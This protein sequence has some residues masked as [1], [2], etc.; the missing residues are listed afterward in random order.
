MSESE[1]EVTFDQLIKSIEQLSSQIENTKLVTDI[2]LPNESK[3]SKTKED[4]INRAE[5][6][7]YMKTS[8]IDNNNVN[9]AVDNIA[10]NL[11][12]DLLDRNF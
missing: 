2:G 1:K 3:I 12:D 7:D 6:E 8:E 11:L 5:Y 4:A 10:K 9:K